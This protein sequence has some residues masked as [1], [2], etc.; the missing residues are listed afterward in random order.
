M[1]LSKRGRIVAFEKILS[2]AARNWGSRSKKNAACDVLRLER[3]RAE[4]KRVFEHCR[5]TPSRT[6]IYWSNDAL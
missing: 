2:R 4:P 3:S 5:G 6:R 1:R